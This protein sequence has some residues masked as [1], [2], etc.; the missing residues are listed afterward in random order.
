LVGDG[1][2]REQLQ[3]QIAVRRLQDYFQFAGLVM[4]NRIPYYLAAMDVVVHVS[5]REGLARILPQALLAGVAVVSFDVDGARE[6]VVDGRTGRLIPPAD[7]SQLADAICQLAE[8]PELRRRLA[9]AG[10]TECQVRFDH[11]RMTAEIRQ[12]Y[13]RILDQTWG[14]P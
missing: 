13:G 10:R 4:P 14:G 1:I 11:R 2:L 7:T 6:V 5:L 8:D 12:L 9:A 3:R